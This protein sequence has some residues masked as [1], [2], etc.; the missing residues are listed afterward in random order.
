M[1][2]FTLFKSSLFRFS[3][4]RAA[5]N[6]PFWKVIFYLVFLSVILAL[7]ITKQMFSVMREIKNDGQKIAEKLPDFKIDK[8]NLHTSKDAE[9]FI[10][11]TNSIIFTFDPEGKR[12]VS[13][14]STD[15]IGNAVSLGLLKD[16]FVIGLPDSGMAESLFG[17][18]QFEVPYTKG[19]LD[20]LSSQTIKKSL[21]TASIPFWIKLLIFI[22]TLYPTLINL[23]INLLLIAVGA[24][25]YSKIRLYNLRFIDCLKVVTYCATLPVI[26]SS[27]LHF[28]NWSFDDSFLIVFISLLIFFFTT[29]KE[30]RHEPPLV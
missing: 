27:L 10:Y 3:D 20:G 21:D 1:N 25:L 4:L 28:F 18:N 14:I 15:S 12:T 19:S 11:Q 5:K 17:A 6:M 30:E 26:L 13:D 23:I 8:G 9:G 22:F 16:S 7:P 24:N 2:S 29:S